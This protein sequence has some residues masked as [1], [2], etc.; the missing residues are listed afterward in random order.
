MMHSNIK[1]TILKIEVDTEQ[2]IKTQRKK[3]EKE[4]ASFNLD[5]EKSV[6]VRS[7]RR[8]LPG[9]QKG[10]K[11]HRNNLEKRDNALKEMN[12]VQMDLRVYMRK[13]TVY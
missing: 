2:K 11:Q 1:K 9:V 8:N 5:G 7:Y 6:V 12:L 4:T 13:L 10:K 3:V